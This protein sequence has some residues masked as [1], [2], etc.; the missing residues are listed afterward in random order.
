MSVVPLA[1][2]ICEKTN[3]RDKYSSYTI[4]KFN[5]NIETEISSLH[6]NVT[7][8]NSLKKNG[9]DRLSTENIIAAM[10][11]AS[12]TSSAEWTAHLKNTKVH[13][14]TLIFRRK[15]SRL[16]D[17]IEIAFLERYA[18]MHR[19]NHRRGLYLIILFVI[20]TTWYDY[21]SLSD[22]S[23]VDKEKD[24]LP[25][26]KDLAFKLLLLLRYA[27]V[28]PIVLYTIRHTYKSNYTLSQTRTL[29]CNAV[30]LTFP[31][32][33]NII[34]RDYGVSW[35][36]LMIMFIYNWTPI[37]FATN[38][39]LCFLALLMYT[40]VVVAVGSEVYEVFYSLLFILLV[41][42]PS[43]SKEY[44]LRMNFMGDIMMFS[45]HIELSVEEEHSRVLLASMLPETIVKQLKEGKKLIAEEYENVSIL[46]AEVCDF[47]RITA[48][49]QPRH[50]I[51]LL[52]VVFS[53]FDQLVDLHKAH[54]VETVGAVY[55][56]CAGCPDRATN[57]ADVTASL[58]LELVRCIPKIQNDLAQ[59]FWGETIGP[60]I[61]V[62]VGLNSGFVI[63]GVV[64]IRNPRF[65]VK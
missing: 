55:M 48:E 46:F 24:M 35:F 36:C 19:V 5:K 11:Y 16:V 37:R 44:S 56:V 61:N 33:Y 64:G 31:I 47:D 2:S 9:I 42:I 43:Y 20:S 51:E 32:F 40:A 12:V 21:L 22:D 59:F 50:V 27:Y 28:I 62:R 41:S 39:T 30:V 7:S 4:S 29:V 13:F 58:A 53:T 65:K 17:P 8:L 52:N 45:Q 1:P 25:E 15:D 34:S 63:A 26:E 23:F 6:Q 49:L 38:S 57:H 18:Y 3:D 60:Q 14:V 54:K 10:H